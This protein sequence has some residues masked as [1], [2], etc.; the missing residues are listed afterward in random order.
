MLEKMGR[1]ITL[2]IDETFQ[3]QK[4]QIWKKEKTGPVIVAARFDRID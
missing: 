4:V 1:A 2:N 3:N